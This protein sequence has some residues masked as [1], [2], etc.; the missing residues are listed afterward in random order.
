MLFSL[1][2][3]AMISIQEKGEKAQVHNHIHITSHL[4]VFWQR[5]NDL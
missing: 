4:K 3:I 2:H 5:P 1:L